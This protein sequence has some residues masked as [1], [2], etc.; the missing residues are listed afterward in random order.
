M[1]PEFWHQR[2]RDNLIGFHL[3]G[4]NPQL[5][6]Y[7]SELSVEV[8]DP[9]FVPLCGK[10]VDMLWLAERH[11]VIGVELSPIA[12][13]AFFEENGLESHETRQGRFS[14]CES[15]RVRI[16]CGD[17]FDLEPQP[18][19]GVRAVYDRASLIALPEDM[20]SRYVEHLGAVLPADVEMLLV[21]LDYP[22]SQMDGPPFAVSESDVQELFADGWSIDLLHSDDVLAREARFRE[23]G[24][25]HMME[26]VFHLRRIA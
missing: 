19:A 11:P 24:L 16:L 22:Q 13:E 23:R 4:V 12:V 9:A 21:T 2:W 25:T 7:W 15:E 18:L 20:R 17:F 8:G 5:E 6:A 1:E 26:N 10:S 14:V 3:P